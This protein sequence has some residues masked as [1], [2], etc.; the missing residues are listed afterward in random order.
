MG[1]GGKSVV[2]CTVII[3]V[4][5][6]GWMIYGYIFG[7]GWYRLVFRFPPERQEVVLNGTA[8]ME[9][10]WRWLPDK[11]EMIVEVNDDE[12]KIYQSSISSWRA[13]DGL[14]ILF[15]SDH[16]GRLSTEPGEKWNDYGVFLFP[17]NR[18]GI[19]E[20]CYIANSS[21]MPFYQGAV[22]TSWLIIG[23][24]PD[25]DSIAENLTG[26]YVVFREG[27]GYTFHLSIPIKLIDVSPPTPIHISFTDADRI[28]EVM[29]DFNPQPT[30]YQTTISADFI[31]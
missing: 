16:N 4:I 11:L 17:D 14:G 12:S 13:C 29:N 28:V 10:S 3:S 27:E 25:A 20:H 26:C 1:L 19:S 24:S 6:F 15:D 7:S 9:V 30:T 8:V 5:M 2:F 23:C 22:M 21:A 18:S 31:G